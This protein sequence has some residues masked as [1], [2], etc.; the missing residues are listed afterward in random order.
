MRKYYNEPIIIR[1]LTKEVLDSWAKNNGFK[2]FE[3]A[4]M[5]IYEQ[6]G[7][8]AISILNPYHGESIEYLL[9]YAIDFPQ[10]ILFISMAYD[11]LKRNDGK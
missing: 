7:H 6:G 3:D 4:E 5:Q 11:N 10:D 1:K 9:R 8:D 2:N